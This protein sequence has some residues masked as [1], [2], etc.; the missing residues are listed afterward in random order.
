MFRGDDLT[1]VT[2]YST[3]TCIFCNMAKEYFKENNIDY[4]DFNV[5]ENMIK[6]REMI[7][8]SQQQGVPVIDIDGRIIIGFD[9]AAIKEA[10]EIK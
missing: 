3:P 5:A 2:I 10:L 8:K 1:K 7:E 6:A 9:K 4:E